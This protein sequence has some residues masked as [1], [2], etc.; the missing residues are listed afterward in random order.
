MTLAE[1][2]ISIQPTSDPV[3]QPSI[4]LTPEH[5]PDDSEMV[6]N[7]HPPATIQVGADLIPTTNSKYHHITGQP[8]Q[9]K[10]PSNSNHGTS[11]SKCLCYQQISDQCA[12]QEVKEDADWESTKWTVCLRQRC[13]L[14]LYIF[15]NS[16]TVTYA[17]MNGL[18]ITRLDQQ[19]SSR[20]TMMDC[21]MDR[22]KCAFC[23][24]CPQL[25]LTYLISH[26][27]SLLP[28]KYVLWPS[29]TCCTY[30]Q[31]F[32]ELGHSWW[33]APLA[34]PLSFQLLAT[35][36]PLCII[37]IIL[38]QGSLSATVL[39]LQSHCL[40]GSDK[41]QLHMNECGLE[42][43]VA[44]CA[45]FYYIHLPVMY[46]TQY[47]QI[48]HNPGWCNVSCSYTM[49]ADLVQSRVTCKY[50]IWTICDNHAQSC[51]FAHVLLVPFFCW[52]CV[53]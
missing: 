41:E 28:R 4:V 44:G 52:D 2:P 35:S 30:W 6:P 3:L 47:Q 45:K 13:S 20:H 42:Q 34:I 27:T 18:L 22:K 21:Q 17:H 49:S 23:L 46:T 7:A 15:T 5:S 36:P 25:G 31:V 51:T 38:A 37:L 12:G 39:S 50:Y 11:T 43:T 1:E 16:I 33:M 10:Y 19:P 53:T 14:P 32:F 40:M 24:I 8:A 9:L 26:T 29:R 48:W